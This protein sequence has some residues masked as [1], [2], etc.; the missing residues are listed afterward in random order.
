M[1]LRF[2]LTAMADAITDIYIVITEPIQTLCDLARRITDMEYHLSLIIVD[3]S[4]DTNSKDNVHN[5]ERQ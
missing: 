4:I 3:P 5:S 2:K 1:T